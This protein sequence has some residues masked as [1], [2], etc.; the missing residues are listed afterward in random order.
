MMVAVAPLMRNK[1]RR[2]LARSILWIVS[3]TL[4]VGRTLEATCLSAS[5][6][7]VLK[8]GKLLSVKNMKWMILSVIS[9]LASLVSMIETRGYE[10]VDEDRAY[11]L[12]M[13]MW[14]WA[15]GT[16]TGWGVVLLLF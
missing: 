5:A 12:K 11:W 15:N 2:D 4:L 3:V 1:S 8:E 14:L 9:F 6:I 13:Q 7:L 16:K 10:V